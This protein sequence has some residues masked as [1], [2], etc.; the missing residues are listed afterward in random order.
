MDEKLIL[1]PSPHVRAHTN[2]TRIMLDVLIALAPAAVASMLIYGF[3][4]FI[5]IADTVVAAVAAEWISRRV[6]KRENT[7]GDL[8][9]V[10]TGV[11]LAFNLPPTINPL[12]AA[13]GAVIAIVVVKQMFGG[14][15]CNFVNP[16][17]AARVVLLTSFPSAMT[18]WTAPI[19]LGSSKIDI[20]TCATPLAMHAA[21]EETPLLKMFLGTTGGCLGETCAAALLLGGVYLV[22]RR[23]ISPVIPLVYMGTAALMALLLGE[24]PLFQLLAGGLILG[25]VFMATDYTTSP[26]TL[27][28]KVIYAV[29]CGVLTML[30]RHFGNLPEGVS[31]SILL[32]NILTPLIERATVPKPFGEGRLG[33]GKA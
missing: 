22:I 28:G 5:I 26:M 1:S 15:G 8:S 17:L 33:R 10:V 7:V 11:L 25:A 6:M 12:I 16:A 2:T 20:V 13:F 32:M 31:F 9:A 4:S 21:G 19:K 3:H 23:V 27:S 14:I 24:D 18:A 29:G 30:I